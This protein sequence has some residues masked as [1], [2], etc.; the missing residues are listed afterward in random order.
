MFYRSLQWRL[1]SIFVLITIFLLVPVGL[2]LNSRLE[3]SYYDEFR[4][5]IDNGFSNWDINSDSD[6][7]WLKDYLNEKRNAAYLF[8]IRYDKSYSIIDKQDITN[9]IYSSDALFDA[10]SPG[11]KQLV[12]EILASDNVLDVAAGAEEGSNRR[13]I[14]SNNSRYFDYA[15]LVNLSD[16]EYILYFRYYSQA[17]KDIADKFNGI[18]LR[19]LFV[20]IAISLILGYL[21]SKTI[22]MP[23]V[24]IM[25]KARELAAGD[26]DQVLEVKSEDEIGQLTRTFNQMAGSLKGTLTEI[27]SEKNKI[28]TILNYMTDGVL[29]FN[30]EGKVIHT[31]PASMKILG[32]EEFDET[33]DEFAQQYGLSI[34]LDGVLHLEAFNSIE[35]SIIVDG[36]FI[37][38]YF[39]AFTDES[40]KPDGVITVLQDITQQQKLENMRRE[41]VANVSHELRTPLTSIKSYAE[42]LLEGA[43]EDRETS[44]RFLKVI[45]TEA[46]R[47]TRLVKDLLQLTRLD[48]NQM[49][50]TMKEIPVAGL[51]KGCIEKIQIEAQNRQQLIETRQTSDIPDIIAD[52][53][54]IEQVVLNILSNAIKYTPAGGKVTV[55]LDRDDENVV[56]KVADTGIGIPKEDLPRIFER[57]YRVDK[58]RSREMGGTGL[59]LAIAREI[60]EAHQG[61]ISINSE[62]G[63]GTEVV[64]KLPAAADKEKAG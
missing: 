48:N 26:F 35:E 52:H 37:R 58:A 1:V 34:T 40:K 42:T 38:A 5:G 9:I 21:L 55:R 33:F 49:Q 45:D 13:L 64:V 43:M 11:T 46:D 25:H 16:G 50:W 8:A 53:D 56:L 19:S 39:L 29:A 27:S 3:A 41:F 60:V 59:G 30:L 15:R 20:S 51:V 6:L 62:L 22:T 17:W 47:M 23:I 14:N 44:E 63:K 28:E 32:R 10:G 57:F 18:I 24:S 12:S 7:E 2:L 61:S 31:N 36:K 4:K 54:R